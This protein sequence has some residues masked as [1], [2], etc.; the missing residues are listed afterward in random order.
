MAWQNNKKL[1]ALYVYGP[2]NRNAWVHIQGDGWKVIWN[3]H[4]CQSEV[5]VTMAAHAKNENRPVNFYEESNK[6]KTIYVF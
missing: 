5:M 2:Q 3:Q 4:D 1:D 6:I